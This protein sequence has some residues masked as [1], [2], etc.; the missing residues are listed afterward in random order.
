MKP[1]DESSCPVVSRGHITHLEVYDSAIDDT[2]PVPL[3]DLYPDATG[4]IGGFVDQN[5]GVT[6]YRPVL[7]V[8]G[9]SY[10]WFAEEFIWLPVDLKDVQ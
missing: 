4:F 6:T 10:Y 5:T 8:G 9:N 2:K 3:N 7:S 1:S